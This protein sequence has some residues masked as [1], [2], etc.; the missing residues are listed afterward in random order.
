[1]IGGKGGGKDKFAMGGGT[2][3]AGTDK[4]AADAITVVDRSVATKKIRTG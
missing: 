2:Q 1:M 4:L 3:I